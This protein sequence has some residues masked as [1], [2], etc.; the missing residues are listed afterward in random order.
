MVAPLVHIAW[1][2]DD[3]GISGRVGCIFRI[4]VF[5]YDAW[6]E[7]LA[8]IMNQ[9]HKL[10]LTGPCTMIRRNERAEVRGPLT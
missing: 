7:R 2:G 1:P 6:A 5:L 4:K 10:V 3:H 8:F 9:A